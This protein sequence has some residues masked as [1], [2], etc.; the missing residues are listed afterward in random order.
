MKATDPDKSITDI[1]IFNGYSNVKLGGYLLKMNYL[2][3]TIMR[4][5]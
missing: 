5:V 2:K 1:V 3:L 4:G